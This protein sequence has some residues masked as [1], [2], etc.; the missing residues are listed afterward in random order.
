MM[1]HYD[2]SHYFL[3]SKVVT[4]PKIALLI[5]LNIVYWSNVCTSNIYKLVS[6]WLGASAPCRFRSLVL[7]KS[8]TKASQAQ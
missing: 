6:R 3:S 4:S 8:H 2:M 1:P 5:F 7:Y